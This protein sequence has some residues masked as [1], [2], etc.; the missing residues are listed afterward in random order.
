MRNARRGKTMIILKTF[1][2]KD[3]PELLDWEGNWGSGFTT[4]QNIK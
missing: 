4:S 3:I 1:K 2:K